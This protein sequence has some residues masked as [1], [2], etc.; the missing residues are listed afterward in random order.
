MK[1]MLLFAWAN[2]KDRQ[3]RT[4]FPDLESSEE[5][6]LMTESSILV[7]CDQRAFN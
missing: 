2:R 4:C 7:L 3:W 6:K 1:H 5:E